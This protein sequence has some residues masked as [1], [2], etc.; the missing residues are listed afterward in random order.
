MNYQE[1]IRAVNAAQT[2]YFHLCRQGANDDAI[3]EAIETMSRLKAEHKAK[4]GMLV[5]VDGEWI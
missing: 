1:S 4:F 3:G 5:R 2:H